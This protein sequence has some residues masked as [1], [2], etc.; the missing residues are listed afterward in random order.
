MRNKLSLELYK[1]VG[2]A[3]RQ[4][5]SEVYATSRLMLPPLVIGLLVLYGEVKKFLGVEFQN[6]E[7]LHYLVWSGCVIISLIWIF[8]VSRVAQ[9]VHWHL[10][11]ISGFSGLKDF[12]VRVQIGGKRTQE[13]SPKR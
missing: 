7:T 6:A 5:I 13:D 2:N 9:V 3:V 4:S 10:E 12:Q 8:N 11:T 1:E